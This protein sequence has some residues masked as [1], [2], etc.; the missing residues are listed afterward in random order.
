VEAVR[1]NPDG[2]IEWV[3][4]FERHGA[5]FSDSKIVD[6]KTLVERIKAGKR[7][8]AGR[9][10]PYLAGTFEVG[11]SLRLLKSGEREI[12]ITDQAQ[13]SHDRLEGVPLI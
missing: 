12:L 6:R 1:Y 9:R 7:I 10:V 8:V 11:A 4:L 13:A 5:T 2:E 3:R